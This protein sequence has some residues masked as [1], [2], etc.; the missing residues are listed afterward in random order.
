[1]KTNLFQGIWIFKWNGKMI[2][3]GTFYLCWRDSTSNSCDVIR[4]WKSFPWRTCVCSY[5]YIFIQSELVCIYIY[6]Y[7]KCKVGDLS[8]G[9]PKAPFSIATTI[10][11]PFSGLLY[12]TLDPYFIMPSI[13]QG[14]IKYHF[15]VFGMTRPGIEPQS[16]GP[17]VNILFI[18]SIYIYIYIY[19][20]HTHTHTEYLYTSL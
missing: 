18:R 3:F 16:P 7:K 12:F 20:T 4:V 11:T 6:I 1:M 14:G 13:K 5:L 15:W 17:L 8:G 9:D 19:Y 2:M 10:A